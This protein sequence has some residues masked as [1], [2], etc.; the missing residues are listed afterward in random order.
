LI[1]ERRFARSSCPTEDVQ[2]RLACASKGR[3]DNEVK[4]RKG[5]ATGW[6]ACE[7]FSKILGLTNALG[8]ETGV[9][10]RMVLGWS[11]SPKKT[12]VVACLVR[13][14]IM[15][16]LGMSDEMHLLGTAG[17]EDGETRRRRSQSILEA[18]VEHAL[19]DWFRLAERNLLRHLSDVNPAT[20]KIMWSVSFPV[21]G[22]S[23][24]LSSWVST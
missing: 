6:P 22:V 19:G 3:N 20:R 17:E 10:Y 18:I 15:M 4:S 5:P 24:K 2:S 11:I 23:S 14:N 7:D 12:V 16:A 13:R 8:C 1:E 9:V 21:L